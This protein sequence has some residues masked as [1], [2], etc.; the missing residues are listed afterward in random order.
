MQHIIAECTFQKPI[1]EEEDNRSAREIDKQLDLS[2]SRWIRSYYSQDRLRMIC[3]FEAPDPDTVKAA[4]A[5]A[6]CPLDTAWQAT[7]FSGETVESG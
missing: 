7:V 4:Y 1:T 3:E 5:S 2:G 6:G